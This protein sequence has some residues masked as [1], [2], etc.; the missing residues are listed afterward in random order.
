MSPT[1]LS[2]RAA[3]PG[4]RCRTWRRSPSVSPCRVA[5]QAVCSDP[6]QVC[7]LPRGTPQSPPGSS[8][9]ARSH[10][11][12]GLRRFRYGYRAVYDVPFSRN[13]L[14]I[15]RAPARFISARGRTPG[16]PRR[17][18]RALPWRR[19]ARRAGSPSSSGCR[20]GTAPPS[21]G[22][23]GSLGGILGE[24]GHPN[25]RLH[26]RRR[27]R[28]RVHPFVVGADGGVDR[29]GRPVDGYVGEQLVFA[30]AAF[31][32]APAVAPGAE[33]LDYPGGQAGGGI[34]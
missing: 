9:T 23:E 28:P 32:V 14:G 15:R 31:H 3:A 30:V 10:N 13:S 20:R 4:S 25:R 22:E 1:T 6:W 33:L 27:L 26:A 17:A 21:P 19:S 29:L 12:R 7:P 11:L 2:G 16:C 34:V 24:E 5:P 18:V 8:G